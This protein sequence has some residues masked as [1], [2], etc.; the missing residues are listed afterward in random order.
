GADRQ[1]ADVRHLHVRGERREPNHYWY[2][3]RRAHAPSDS[4][5]RR[6]PSGAGG[7]DRRYQG[8]PDI[9][10]RQRLGSLPARP[11]VIGRG[12]RSIRAI[13]PEC[14]PSELPRISTFCKVSMTSF[15]DTNGVYP[16]FPEHGTHVVHPDDLETFTKLVPAGKVFTVVGEGDGYLT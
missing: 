15:I 8:R 12:T 7:R 13:A 5:G 10:H 9:L 4:C 11:R 2:P 16:W 6:Q 1:Q 14:I 3:R